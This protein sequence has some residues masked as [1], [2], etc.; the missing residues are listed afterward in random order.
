MDSDSAPFWMWKKACKKLRRKNACIFHTMF[1]CMVYKQ[2]QEYAYGFYCFHYTHLLGRRRA[3]PAS[4]FI[5]YHILKV[6]F[7][8]EIHKKFVNSF[9]ARSIKSDCMAASPLQSESGGLPERQSLCSQSSHT[10]ATAIF[11]TICS[12][13]SSLVR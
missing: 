4:F 9:H 7:S 12:P 13:V 10:R 1:P 5:A 2:I 11:L 6:G 8:L 3:W